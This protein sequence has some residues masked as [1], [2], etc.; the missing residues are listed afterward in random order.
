MVGIVLVSHSQT[1]AEGLLELIRQMAPDAPIALAAGTE[2]ADEPIGTDPVRVYSAIESVY[3]DDGVLILMD[4]GSAI[5]SAEAA[6]EFLEPEH[7]EQIYLCEAPLV[8]GAVVAAVAAAGGLPLTSVMAEARSALPNKIIQ[9]EPVLRIK[10]ESAPSIVTNTITRDVDSDAELTL[11]VPNRLGLHARPAARL[12]ELINRYDAAVILTKAHRTVNAASITQVMT[13]GIRQGD[14]LHFV[15]GGPDSRA[16]VAAIQGLAKDNFGDVD[17]S[18]DSDTTVATPDRSMEER[19]PFATSAESSQIVGIPASRGIGL[20]KAYVHKQAIPKVERQSI[21]DVV[22]EKL[23]LTEA[24]IAVR[25]ELGALEATLTAR[26]SD[27]EGILAAQRLM[28]MDETLQQQAHAHISS[29]KVN[30]EWAWQQTIELLL[31]QYAE[32]EDE[33][34]R[35]RAIDVRDVS[36]RVLLHLVSK[37]ER[38]GHNQQADSVQH[39]TTR[40]S[41]QARP[42]M[43]EPRILI[44]NELSPSDAAN[45]TPAMILGIITTTGGATDHAAILARSLGIPA[46]VG[47][48]Q[49]LDHITHG[50]EIALNGTTGQIWTEVSEA[51]RTEL[52]KE[53]RASLTQRQMAQSIAHEPAV[54]RDGQRIEVAANI[55][56]ATEVTNA[57]AAGAEG[58]G[59]FRT[60]LLFMERATAP[61]EETQYQAYRAAAEALGERPLLIRTL[62]VGGDKPLPYLGILAE[63]N[64]FLGWRG[65]RY[66]LDNP[67]LF[68]TQLRAILRA[69]SDH[70][71]QIMFPMVS[72]VAEVRQARLLL[73]E[74]QRAL[75]A[76][77]IDCANELAVGIMVETPA[78]VFNAQQLATEV[79]FFSIGTNDLTQYLMAADRSNANVAQLIDALQPP[80]IAAIAQVTEAAHAAGIWVGLCGELAADPLATPLLMGLGLDELSMSSPAIPMVKVQIRRL[81]Q[82]DAIDLAEQIR[83]LGH[84][85]EIRTILTTF[86]KRYG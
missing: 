56:N 7:Q 68:R 19:Q 78:A 75:T 58:V 2:N 61:D 62:D 54:T 38:L 76:A 34:L 70:R 29:A 26:G 40:S 74:E 77:G 59:L 60:E 71:V 21:V 15:A 85:D 50:Q 37:S 3:S 11:R 5:M 72:T 14:L 63:E 22:G 44:T 32:L 27:G 43:T 46:V 67:T 73:Q 80:V 8:E 86:Q 53:Q 57:L 84:V 49:A 1:L 51:L 4:L 6:I 64:P 12:V 52:V 17:Y 10:P 41:V 82:T 18:E 48:M 47:V 20:G 24:L 9:L 69:A 31:A 28:L 25:Q 83:T 30:A 16:V 79:D 33:Y 13:L 66:C 35:N 55:G 36:N 42:L 23:R 39:G 81:N 45:L 65:I